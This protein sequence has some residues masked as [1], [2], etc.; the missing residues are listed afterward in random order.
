MITAERPLGFGSTMR[1]FGP[2]GDG[3]GMAAA[4]LSR[5]KI[6][7]ML[8]LKS[9]AQ[10]SH[11]EVA[12][13]LMVSPGAVASAVGRAR[14]L[15]LT[16]EAVEALSD[17]AL[18]Q[19]LY[20]PRAADVAGQRPEP[21][22]GVDSS[23]AQAPRRDPGV[24][25][26]RVPVGASDRLSLRGVLRALSG[27]GGT[28]AAVDAPSACRRRESVCR[29]CRSAAGAGGRHDGRGVPGELFVAVLGAANYR[30]AEAT[31]TRQS[32]DRIASHTKVHVTLC[33]RP[34]RIARTGS[35]HAE[36]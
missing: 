33:S 15:A 12:R 25:P 36:R 14:V 8:R 28:A 22:P 23:R 11:R 34:A 29:L 30:F 9:V 31:A 5:R 19:P 32:A 35:A 21:G 4:R 27:V 13:S 26:R 18:E 2:L 7:E 16:W 24:A 10:R 6:L 17:D 3:S 1:S 20:G